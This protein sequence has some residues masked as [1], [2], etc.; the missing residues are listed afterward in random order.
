MGGVERGRLYVA[1]PAGACGVSDPQLARATEYLARATALLAQAAES[2]HRQ[3][4]FLQTL[5]GQLDELRT[6]MNELDKQMQILRQKVERD[7]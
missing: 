5:A 3:D 7:G 4:E 6:K 2:R 1:T